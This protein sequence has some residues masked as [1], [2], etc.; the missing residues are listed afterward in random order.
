MREVAESGLLLGLAWFAAVNAVVTLA[1]RLAAGPTVGTASERGTWPLCLR[2]L[3]AAASLLMLTVFLPAHWRLEPIDT[4]EAGESF[5]FILYLAAGS[6]IVILA[7]SAARA[8]GVVRAEWR[9]RACRYLPSVHGDR[10]VREV[11][12]LN[13]VSLVGVLGT[14]ILVGDVVL[15][16]LTPAELA[17]ALAHE[18][19]HRLVSDN[20]KR[21]AI[22][23]APDFFW[24]FRSARALEAKWH[25]VAECAADARAV[26]GSPARGLDLASALVKVSRL[27]ATSPSWAVSP[28]WSSLHDPPLLDM[29]VRRLVGGVLQAP[30]PPRRLLPGVALAAGV[31]GLVASNTQVAAFVHGLTEVLIAHLP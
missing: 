4:I 11:R 30:R 20:L 27:T 8:L 5:G 31:L 7:R 6:A 3:P 17:V 25:V 29:R 18:D 2:L 19:A 23:C 26:G 13:G 9:L 28:S 22:H 24:L 16:T 12:D 15:R 1:C 14:R 21:F 10:A